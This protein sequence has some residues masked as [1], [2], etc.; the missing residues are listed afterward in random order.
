MEEHTVRREGLGGHRERDRLRL[1]EGRTKV[2]TADGE[3]HVLSAEEREQ[4]RKRR[5]AYFM[6]RPK[7][8]VE[9]D[10][11]AEPVEQKSGN[12]RST[13]H[14]QSGGFLKERTTQN[15]KKIASER[16]KQQTKFGDKAQMKVNDSGKSRTW[17][18]TLKNTCRW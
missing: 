3:L 18:H 11:A 16:D 9:K 15:G 14:R 8:D 2:P 6:S 17:F 10:T 1:L 12:G 4:V 7:R 5:E 13:N